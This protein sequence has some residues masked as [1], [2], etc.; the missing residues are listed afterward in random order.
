MKNKS[1]GYSPAELLYG[2]NLTLNSNWQPNGEIDNLEE[3][4]NTRIKIINTDLP[5]I[6]KLS[7][8]KSV[9]AKRKTEI[10]YN[11]NVKIFNFNL[12]DKVLKLVQG[13]KNKFDKIFEGPY[14]IQQKLTKG[15]YVI[16]DN[17]AN[18]EIVNG[19]ILKLYHNINGMIP[20]VTSNLNTKLKRFKK[21]RLHEDIYA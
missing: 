8:E 4:I 20:E 11:K 19:D 2:F 3:E 14:E 13:E 1:T 10:K 5:Q 17:N 7:A 12:G 9:S 16:S 18:R 15:A 21:P 6:R